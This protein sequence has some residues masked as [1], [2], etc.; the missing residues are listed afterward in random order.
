M[1]AVLKPMKGLAC[2]WELSEMFYSLY[3]EPRPQRQDS[4]GA[5]SAMQF[6]LGKFTFALRLLLFWVLVLRRCLSLTSHLGWPYDL[7]PVYLVCSF[8]IK[9]QAKL[10][11][12]SR[13]T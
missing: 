4:L 8:L 7:S 5:L 6:I 10:S 12:V 1:N 2:Y 13:C 9:L 11:E 3:L